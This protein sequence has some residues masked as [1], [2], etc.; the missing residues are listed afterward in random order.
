MQRQAVIDCGSNSFRLLIA[1]VENGNI[2]EVFREY[3]TVRLG[4]G[5]LQGGG[6]IDRATWERCYQA[7]SEFKMAIDHSHSQRVWALGTSALRSADNGEQ[8]IAAVRKGLQLQI[9]IIGGEEEARY[10]FAGATNSAEF[11]PGTAVIDIGGGSTE[12]AIAGSQGLWC[13]SVPLGAVRLTN[14]FYSGMDY[15][16]AVARQRLNQHVQVLWCVEEVHGPIERL[17]GVAGTIT[18]LVALHKQLV[19]YQPEH[20]RDTRLSIKEVEVLREAIIGK[21][22]SNRKK[23]LG[24]HPP[25]RAD[26]ILAGID[27]LLTTMRVLKQT[28]I[29][30]Q[31]TCLLEGVLILNSLRNMQ[32]MIDK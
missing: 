15:P 14:S 30:V 3:R 20:I 18:T 16:T 21:S 12:L 17:I 1:D 27:I 13:K 10:S 32:N 24:M 28:V 22:P 26:I 25:A 11:E 4:S 19:E 6:S 29:T 31:P 9:E 7:L 2:H 8:F 5:L 23:M